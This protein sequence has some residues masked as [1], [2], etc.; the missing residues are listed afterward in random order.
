L[1]FC[2]K[3]TS[4]SFLLTRAFLSHA[5]LS[6]RSHFF[7]HSILFLFWLKQKNVFSWHFVSG[8]VKSSNRNWNFR[9]NWLVRSL[10]NINRSLVS[11]LINIPTFKDKVFV[12]TLSV[13]CFSLKKNKERFNVFSFDISFCFALNSSSYP[14]SVRQNFFLS[15]LKK[16]QAR[17]LCAPFYLI[18]LVT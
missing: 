18:I 8:R 13:I 4:I 2:L 9:S 11:L 5:F 6:F 7:S 16:K 17:P 15:I 12:S 14:A 10:G 1:Q 3:F